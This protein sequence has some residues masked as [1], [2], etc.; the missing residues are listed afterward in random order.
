MKKKIKIMV[1]ILS[2][3]LVTLGVGYPGL[4]YI[5]F[6]NAERSTD[7]DK[8]DDNPRRLTIIYRRGCS[9]CQ[10]T[11]PKF[12]LE[13]GFSNKK[14]QVINANKLDPDQLEQYDVEKTP[15]FR[16]NRE[17][18]NTTNMKIIEKLWK[19]SK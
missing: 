10:K 18:Y 12:I 5:N 3:L 19:A 14:Y 8:I 15:T 1:I 4:L 7:V 16:L 11:I 13:Q 6:I 9:R 2:I 17:S